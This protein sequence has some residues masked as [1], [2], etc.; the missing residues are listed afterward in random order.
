VE[1]Y[2][3]ARLVVMHNLF[4][5][6]AEKVNKE[7]LEE[8]DYMVSNNEDWAPTKKYTFDHMVV[9][10][11][12]VKKDDRLSFIYE[13]F[14]RVKPWILAVGPNTEFV[15]HT[16]QSKCCAINFCIQARNNAMT[17][18]RRGPNMRRNHWNVHSINYGNPGQFVLI[19]NMKQHM[20]LNLDNEQ[21]IYTFTIP[22]MLMRDDYKNVLNEMD[23]L[24]NLENFSTYREDSDLKMPTSDKLTPIQLESLIF[25]KVQCILLDNGFMVS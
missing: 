25:A 17:V 11:R 1:I 15:Y 12:L 18:F 8:L 5:T 14:G 9:P 20:V 10:E 7:V 16:D 19:N 6:F 24:L 2:G 22:C 3:N 4:T 13:R 23:D 21:T